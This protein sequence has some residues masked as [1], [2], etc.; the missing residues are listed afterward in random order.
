MLEKDAKIINIT[1][2][3]EFEQF[4]KERDRYLRKLK[5]FKNA[6]I[7]LASAWEHCGEMMHN[8]TL[9][10]TYPFQE[11]FAEVTFKIAQWFYDL[12]EKILIINHTQNNTE[13]GECNE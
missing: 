5:N 8:L 13:K 10:G 2:N 3:R 7:E 12:E 11:D 4:L 6:A 9:G 1:Q